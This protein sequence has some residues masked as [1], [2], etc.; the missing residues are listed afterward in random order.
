M[1]WYINWTYCVGSNFNNP[2]VILMRRSS[3]CHLNRYINLINST[4]CLI[5]RSN[6]PQQV[7]TAPNT[8]RAI[9]LSPYCSQRNAIH[10]RWNLSLPGPLRSHK[11]KWIHTNGLMNDWLYTNIVPTFE[12]RWCMSSVPI[13]GRS[14]IKMNKS[15]F[16]K[17][18]FLKLFPLDKNMAAT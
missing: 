3:D 13:S 15:I 2:I 16:F 1:I 18:F 14:R 8:N 6:S 9:T 12:W 10:S 4:T 17:Q 7:A 5:L 11:L